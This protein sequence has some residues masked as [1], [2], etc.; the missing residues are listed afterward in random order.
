MK[1]TITIELDSSAS[2]IQV[3]VKMGGDIEGVEML[4]CVNYLIEVLQRHSSGSREEVIRD[5]DGLSKITTI[6]VLN[7]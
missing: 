1:K 2:S 4:A 3:D 5:L 6:Q 7:S